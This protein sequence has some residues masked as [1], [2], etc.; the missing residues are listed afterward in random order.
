M[1]NSLVDKV[2]Y[3][4]GRGVNAEGAALIILPTSFMRYMALLAW[5]LLMVGS[6]DE[7]FV[8]C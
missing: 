2:R 5:T 7:S 1:W 8:G 4:V 6:I 3:T